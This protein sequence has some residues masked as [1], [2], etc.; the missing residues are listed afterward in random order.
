MMP[1]GVMIVASLGTLNSLNF[2]S[3][4]L[5]NRI[6]EY[7]LMLVMLPIG[8]CGALFA[9]SGLRWLLTAFWPGRLAIVADADGI[10]FHLGP[11]G[12]HRCK[13]DQIKL[14]YPFELNIEDDGEDAVLE[15]LLEPAQ[16]MTT[17]LPRME[18]A[19]E[20]KRI[21]RRIL[22]FTR[23]DETQAADVLRPFVEFI[24]S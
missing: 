21:D 22:Y 12:T 15:S 7:C 19:G 3:N 11:M 17:L 23:L 18:Y 13:I 5:T 2:T 16:Q 20:P 10:V 9:F 1:A 24:R 8:L 14:R 6:T 4:P